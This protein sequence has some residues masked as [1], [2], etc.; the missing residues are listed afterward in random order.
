MD[1]FSMSTL[2]VVV[3]TE[4]ERGTRS[5]R[6]APVTAWFLAASLA[7][8]PTVSSAF[9][10]TEN[11]GS[12]PTGN[13][14]SMAPVVLEN[15]ATADQDMAFSQGVTRYWTS[16]R[17]M[18]AQVLDMPV[19]DLT[20]MDSQQSFDDMTAVTPQSHASARGEG[21]AI[22]NR[23]SRLH[24]RLDREA[25][26]ALIKAAKDRTDD[27]NSTLDNTTF[28]RGTANLDFSSSRLVPRSARTAY[29]YRTVG[30]LFFSKPDGDYVCS[31]SIIG[32]RLVL[33]AGHCVYGNHDGTKQFWRNFL[34]VPAFYYGQ[35]PYQQWSWSYVV[36]P[37]SWA[38]SPS[39]PNQS[40]F[41]IIEARD[42]VVGSSLTRI[43]AWLGHLGWRTYSLSNNHVKQMGY[44]CNLDSCQEMHQV[45]S[46]DYVNNSQNTVAYGSDMR[47]GASGG[48]QVMN[49]GNP[50]VGQF[51]SLG[52]M[53][54]VVGVNSYGH[55]TN[56]FLKYIGSSTLNS[57]FVTIWNMACAHKVGNCS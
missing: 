5:S 4:V 37:G 41:A 42:R 12:G 56:V 40:D 36:I 9:L 19:T 44:P 38:A 43:G 20:D 35:A 26:K 14:S 34:F 2:S 45:D 29:P 33:T 17:L 30:K 22:P 46:G 18:N 10:S 50:S 21:K 53:N 57:E 28:D 3:D 51:L 11:G 47:G 31:A 25:L 39:V 1:H 8:V 27:A 23:R 15:D 52:R 32:K 13:D 55:G 24:Q 54:Q 7:L 6:F 49:F 16:E 48:P